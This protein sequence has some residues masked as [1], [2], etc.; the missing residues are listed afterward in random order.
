MLYLHPPS[1]FKIYMTVDIH[2]SWL[3]NLILNGSNSTDVNTEYK[4]LRFNKLPWKVAVYIEFIQDR[5]KSY[6]FNFIK[7]LFA[8]L[9]LTVAP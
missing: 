4:Q 2:V 6:A 9:T 7:L 3:Q 5:G 8:A 1:K